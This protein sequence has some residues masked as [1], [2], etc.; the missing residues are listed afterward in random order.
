MSRI[1]KKPVVIPEGVTVNV[2]EQIVT[3]KGPKG[4]LAHP[5]HPLMSLAVDNGLI[6]V[7]RKEDTKFG[8][9]LHGLTRSLIANMVHG[10]VDGYEKRLELVGTGYRVTKKGNGVSMTLGFSHPMDVVPPTGITIDVEGNTAM[11]V[12]GIDKYLVGQTAADIRGL[13]PPEPYKGKGIRYSGEYVRRKAGKQAKAGA[14][15]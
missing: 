7:D 8:R 3:V 4:E 1:G 9:S 10:V 15:A 6:R 5:V 14:A 2:D 12:K 13:R 11:V